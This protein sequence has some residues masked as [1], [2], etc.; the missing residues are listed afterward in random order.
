MKY[1]LQAFICFGFVIIMTV[2]VPQTAYGRTRGVVTGAVVN[3][4]TSPE[5]NDTNRL[6]QASHGQSVY[7]WNVVGNFYRVNIEGGDNVYIAREWVKVTETLAT[8]E[9]DSVVI[10]DLPRSVGGQPIGYLHTSYVLNAT[11]QFDNWVG[12]T[13]LGEP[14]FVELQYITIP[15]FVELQRS[16]VPGLLSLGNEIVEFA[17][18][19]IG[20]RYLWGGTTPNG[21]DCSGFMVY[22]LGNFGISVNRVSR[23]MALN[24]TQVSR[25]DLQPADL[26]F[27]SGTQGSSRITH[28][29]MY[30]GGGR[31]IHSSTHGVG[32]TISY[33]CSNW[34]H[35]RFVTARRVI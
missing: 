20:T 26:V 1:L 16:R 6:F 28:V 29:G 30:I 10:Y 9:Y 5:I 31:F 19:Y 4:R 21:F 33:M 32:V 14:A 34:N 23:D 24:G 2:L 12:F 15:H 35:P 27:F 18:N 22:V 3:V 11:S 13:H 25:D 7:I 8:V 17:M